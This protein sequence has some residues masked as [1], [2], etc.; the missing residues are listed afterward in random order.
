MVCSSHVIVNSLLVTRPFPRVPLSPCLRVP[1]SPP[2]PLSLILDFPQFTSPGFELEEQI[3]NQIGSVKMSTLASKPNIM[4]KH[5][6]IIV[7]SFCSFFSIL[8]SLTYW[9]H[10]LFSN[11]KSPLQKRASV[12]STP[13][14]RAGDTSH[15]PWT[16]CLHPVRLPPH[17]GGSGVPSSSTRL[18]KVYLFRALQR[19]RPSSIVS[20]PSSFAPLIPFPLSPCPPV[21][22]PPFSLLCSFFFNTRNEDRPG[23]DALLMQGEIKKRMVHTNAYRIFRLRQK[24]YD[25]IMRKFFPGASLVLSSSFRRCAVLFLSLIL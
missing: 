1:V 18:T 12:S 19:D 17:S 2:S 9:F 22:L 7:P 25:T 21:P 3:K 20:H 5:L 6:H 14:S 10:F 11:I 24:K 16:T 8:F 15:G 13:V 23:N 4:S